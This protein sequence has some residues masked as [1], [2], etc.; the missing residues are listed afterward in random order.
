MA[1]SQVLRWID[2][3]NGIKDADATAKQIKLEIRKIRR[4]DDSVSGRKR[5]REL[6]AQLD[7]VQYKPDY[8][9]LIIDREKDYYRACK[10]FSINGVQY[11]RL[12][13]TNGGIKCSTIVF[14]SERVCGE[15]RRRIENGRNPDKQLV[16]AKL[17]AYK[18]LTCS[19]SIPVS[20]PNGIIVVDDC[21]THFKDDI[22]YLTD[23]NDGEPE[24]E[25]R[26]GTEI[27]L[28][29]SDGYG[30]M[31]PSLAKR[32]S[33]ELGLDYVAGGMNTRQCWEKGMVFAFDFLEFA[34][35]IAG[36]YVVRDA[37]GTMRDIREAELI[38][39]TSMLKLW[40]SYESCEDY[41]ANCKANGYTFGI[42]KT[43]PKE[44]ERERGT[45]YQQLQSYTL[46]DE[47][48]AELIQPTVDEIR[49]VLGGD[50]RKAVLFLRGSGLTEKNVVNSPDDIAK[51]LM[52]DN[53]MMDDAYVQNSIYRL[54]RNRIDEAKVG[55]LKVH[56]NYSIVCGDPYAL[57][58]S[59]FNL[60]VTG[61][62]KAG[63]IYNQFW[64]D[65][66][67]EKLACFRAPMTCHNN[68]KI[69]RP[70]R[71][72]EV[73][74]WFQYI[75]TGTVFNV[76][77]TIAAALNGMDY[78][79]DLVMLTDNRILVERHIDTP[80]LMCAQRKAGK[81]IPTEE[82]FVRA[83]IASFGNE[84]GQTTN[85]ITSMFEVQ[86]H[87]KPG[88]RE[89]ETLA[90][91]IKCGQ[92]YQQNSI[93][94]AKGIV[95]KPM[96][97][98]WH[99]RH[100]IG[101]IEDERE[102]EFYRSIVADK[103]PYFMRYIYPQ[104]MKQYTSYM[105]NTE[106]N[107]LRRFGMTVE[108]MAVKPAGELTDEQLEFLKYF[109]SGMPVGTGDC[110]MNRICRAFEEEFDGFAGKTGERSKFNYGIM[111]SNAEYTSY[112]FYK[113]KKSYE[114]FNAR[115]RN[116]AVFSDYERPDEERTAADL[117]MLTES[118]K[119]ECSAICPNRDVLSN[120]I[121]DLCYTKSTTKRFA[122]QLCGEDIIRNLLRNNTGN[123]SFPKE[124]Q[125]G[126]IHYCGRTFKL[127]TVELK[128]DEE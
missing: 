39:T 38:L 91:R 107:S 77:D 12:L 85:W 123:M 93:D 18:A 6:Y 102:Y 59:M 41:L 48:I 50:W 84:I 79:G 97:K 43:C 5:I 11:R 112:Q 95:C 127:V 60:E 49:E 74:H 64:A 66:C 81:C 80:T 124:D 70:A 90:Y 19:A 61:L 126:D 88:S 62:L 119:E 110:V 76:W 106:K 75:T 116:Y 101:K 99:D 72:D 98:T 9:S 22:I 37:W 15:L 65:E 26:P 71:G 27:E 28:D 21:T 67:S 100:A 82:D 32:W 96:P 25:Y 114:Y 35:R 53:R 122:W 118:F 120:I 7:A 3:L 10:G 92:L 46:S 20:Y 45:N 34:E 86:S 8:M 128:E 2:E 117:V 30:L 56:G 14:V 83:N 73:R 33:E 121:L 57:C 105:K 31:L 4:E 103:K 16:T 42:A 125:N 23:E 113:V 87:Y 54:I 111:R 89:Y 29:G 52:A 36:R 69:V 40:D 78:D 51:A 1:D 13:G 115:L 47:D 17:E 63:E 55:V 108:E 44:L 58:Q 94:K 109:R 24:M 68:I 104:L